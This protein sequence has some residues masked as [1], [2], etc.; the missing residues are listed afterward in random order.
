[1]K[2]IIAMLTVCF[3]LISLCSNVFAD[4]TADMSR[5]VLANIKTKIPSTDSFEDFT[6]STRTRSGITMCYYNWESSSDDGAYKSM[7]VTATSDGIITSYSYYDSLLRKSNTTSPAIR[8]VSSDEALIK[9]KELADRLNPELADSITLSK[10]NKY[11]SLIGDD[12]SFRIQ[13]THAGVPVYGDTGYISVSADDFTL[14]G[15]NL[16]YT[17][18][19]VFPDTQSAISHD[20]AKKIYKQKIG[21]KLVYR[22]TYQ[23]DV[24]APYLAYI[25]AD[26]DAYIDA[27]SG[28]KASPITPVHSYFGDAAA[29][30]NES[31]ITAGSGGSSGRFTEAELAE[32][33]NLSQ[34]IGIDRAEKLLRENELVSLS[35]DM[36]LKSSSVSSDN[37]GKY[38]YNLSFSSDGKDAIH[39]SITLNAADGE[40]MRITRSGN[41]IS[42]DSSHEVDSKLAVEYVSSLAPLYFQT[43]GSGEYRLELSQDGAFEFVRY[44]NDVPYYDNKIYLRLN[45]ADNT[46]INYSITRLDADFPATDGIISANDACDKLFEQVSYSMCYYPS[47]SAENMDFCDTALLVYMTEPS[48]ATELYADTGKLIAYMSEPE[49]GAYTDIDGHYA[50]DIIKTLAEYGIG[51]EGAL[52]NPDSVITQKDF[53]ALLTDSILRKDP[54]IL[55]SDFDYTAHYKRAVSNGILVS[56][57]E[58]PD[59]PVTRELAAVYMIRAAGYDEIASLDGIYMSV[60]SDVTD[61]IGHISILNAMG[62]V[63]GYDGLFNPTRSLTRAD[64]MIMI[65]N[66]LSK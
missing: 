37:A 61:H 49:I 25:P 3:M 30:K 66:W 55:S 18:G 54:I 58:A 46:I 39:A 44:I 36:V 11:E 47:C 12:Y 20:D 14:T 41:A 33:E 21:M 1:M 17:P 22:T 60:F 57:E 50:E 63:S 35:D 62:V 10:Y 52:F 13:R 42:Y 23:N 53:I 2:K 31:M 45:S 24:P 32:L 51:F 38:F 59:S 29:D 26:T 48:G 19:L 5:H 9:A 40:I 6:S 8:Q 34:L 64:A 7:N 4:E 28:E 56:C 65:Y 43:D 27:L 16:S 15:Y